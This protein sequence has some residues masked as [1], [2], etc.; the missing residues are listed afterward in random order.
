MTFEPLGI[1]RP[2]DGSVLNAHITATS[3]AQLG[4]GGKYL[5]PLLRRLPDK[6]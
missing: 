2:I 6:K 1:Y 4:M 5:L 3:N